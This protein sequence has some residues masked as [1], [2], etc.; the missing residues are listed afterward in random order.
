MLSAADGNVRSRCVLPFFTARLE[1]RFLL[2]VLPRG[3]PFVVRDFPQQVAGRSLLYSALPSRRS[4]LAEADP[5]EI[6]PLL[7]YDPWWLLRDRHDVPE[8]VRTAVIGT[9]VAQAKIRGRRLSTVYFDDTLMSVAGARVSRW[10]PGAGFIA[11][12]ELFG[13]FR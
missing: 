9:N 7:H 4:P 8:Q 12:D 5:V 13:A 10:L 3:E 2:V 1:V 11:R 6:S